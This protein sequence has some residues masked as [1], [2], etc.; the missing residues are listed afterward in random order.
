MTMKAIA[1]LGGLLLAACGNDP[2]A[3]TMPVDGTGGAAA[4]GTGGAAP[5]A[6]GTGGS[7]PA[8]GRGSGGVAMGT[9]GATGT[10]GA[11]ADGGGTG[12]AQP[13]PDGGGGEVQTT[14]RT[15]MAVNGWVPASKQACV[16]GPGAALFKGSN[17][18][19]HCMTCIPSPFMLQSEECMDGGSLCVKSCG[20]CAPL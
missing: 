20:E 6:D 10:G 7:S 15:C 4:G 17:P 1:I 19:L 5:D 13:G 18:N 8:D 12:G 11:Q 3:G 16:N 14:Y 9:G 2:V